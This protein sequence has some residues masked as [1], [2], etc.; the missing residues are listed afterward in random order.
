MLTFSTIELFPVSSPDFP[1]YNLL[2]DK[3]HEAGYD[4]YMT[5]LCYISMSNYLGEYTFNNHL[6]Y[7]SINGNPFNQ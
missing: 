2:D 6:F 1:A 3:A 5:G 7:R 4:A